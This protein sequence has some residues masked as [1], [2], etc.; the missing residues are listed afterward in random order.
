[1]ALGTPKFNSPENNFHTNIFPE[2]AG[3]FSPEDVAVL[4]S[5]LSE[6]MLDPFERGEVLKMFLTGQ[7]Y[8]SEYNT[9]SFCAKADAMSRMSL[10]GLQKAL[11]DFAQKGMA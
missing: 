11:E 1:M 10:E 7:G 8:G 2:K 5:N 6:P 9:K 3:N 4:H